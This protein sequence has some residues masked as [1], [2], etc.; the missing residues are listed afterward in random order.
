MRSG[1]GLRAAGDRG[2]V[3]AGIEQAAVWTHPLQDMSHWQRF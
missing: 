1:D 2:Q 3:R